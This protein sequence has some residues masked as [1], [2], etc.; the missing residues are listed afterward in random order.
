MVYAVAMTTID[1]FERAMGRKVLWRT[2]RENGKEK[3]VGQLKIQPHA[4]SQENAFYDSSLIALRFGYFK[5]SA[6]DPGDHVPGSTVYTCLS[7]DIVAHESTHAIL[8]GMHR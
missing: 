2:N 4:F 3:Y 5:A 7:H 1:H 8:D 6:N